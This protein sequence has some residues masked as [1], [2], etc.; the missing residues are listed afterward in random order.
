MTRAYQDFDKFLPFIATHSWP[1]QAAIHAGMKCVVN[2]VPDNYPLALHLAEGAV[3][4]VQTPSSYLGYKTLNEM[5]DGTP[6]TM[7]E[8]DIVL[9]G[10]YVDH[11][12][13]SNIVKD[14]NRRIVR[15]NENRPVRFLIPVGGAG[16]GLKIIEH[17]I[18][19]LIPLAKQN[20]I[21]ILLNLGDHLDI[22]ET[23]NKEIKEL[24]KLSTLYIDDFNM[25]ESFC[26]K[27]S[28][29]EDLSG[30]HIFCNKD[31][32]AAVY[33]TNMLMREADVMVTKPSELAFYPVPKLLIR[34]VG[35]HEAY[36]A[37]RSAELGDGTIECRTYNQVNQMA[38]ML[39]K[40]RT[41]IT[42]MCNNILKANRIKIYDGGYEA[43]K[44]AINISRDK[45]KQG[46]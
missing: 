31:I 1:A 40:E 30:I 3:H 34:R 27:A 38:D 17:L 5:R 44:T 15:M 39:I 43:V 12:I 21:C 7:K 14:C 29:D 33:S 11:E 23:L 41:N 19:H 32:F 8:K 18:F 4:T 10:H 6:H 37:L 46:K 16:A 35:A 26:T 28:Y 9:A 36:G 22:L 25:V 20:K 45:K 13:V 2:V 24:K 42:A